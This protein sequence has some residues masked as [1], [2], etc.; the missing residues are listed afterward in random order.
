MA[1]T[2]DF[3]RWFRVGEPI[4]HPALVDMIALQLREGNVIRA[5]SCSDLT[6]VELN[7]MIAP[8]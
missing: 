7:D 8:G 6:G 3:F 1:I 2:G 5:A 4:G